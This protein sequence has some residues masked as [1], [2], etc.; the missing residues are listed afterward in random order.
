MI[1]LLGKRC[2]ACGTHHTLEEFL[3]LPL[4]DNGIG[5]AHGLVWRICQ[6]DWNGQ[7]CRSTLA[8][9][10]SEIPSITNQETAS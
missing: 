3:A 1:A 8:V 6:G 9:D 4:P 10:E 5:R 2:R 7:P